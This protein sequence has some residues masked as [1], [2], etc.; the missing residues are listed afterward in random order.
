MRALSLTQPWAWIILNL[1]KRVENR[2]RNIGN[3]RGPLLLHASKTMRQRDW[4]EAYDF[5]A[6]HFGHVGFA[7][8]I[9][10][11]ASLVRGAIVGR[12]NVIEQIAPNHSTAGL[13]DDQRRWYMGAHAYVLDD[14]KPTPVVYCS[15]LLGFW[16]VPDDV[17]AELTP[18]KPCDH[19][20]LGSN[21]CAKCG[22]SLEHGM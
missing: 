3:Y 17:V 9:P 13:S 20:F 12:C 2:S 22:R 7:D 4:W 16:A 10:K 6:K 18:S 21:T 14:V 1:G 11:P 8:R 19:K 5:C 15:G